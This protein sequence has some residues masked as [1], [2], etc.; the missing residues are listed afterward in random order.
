MSSADDGAMIA[1]IVLVAIIL[2]IFMPLAV[3][4]AMNTLFGMAIAYNF[5][6]WLATFVLCGIVSPKPPLNNKN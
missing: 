4:W 3:I 5:W 1:G 2:V 6:T